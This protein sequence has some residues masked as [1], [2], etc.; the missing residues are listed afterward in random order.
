MR[1][2]VDEYAMPWDHAWSLVK[3]CC[4]YTNHTIL[5]EAL[6]RWPVWLMEK[7][8][9]RHLQIIYDINS[10][11]LAEVKKKFPGDDERLRRMSIIEE[12]GE[13][14]VQMATWPSSEARASTAYPHC[15]RTCCAS[16]CFATSTSSTAPNS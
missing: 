6:E 4:A 5:P 11:F 12:G 15:T 3:R 9:P 10:Q 14:R 16:T 7:L 1:L 2:L 8:L 13:K